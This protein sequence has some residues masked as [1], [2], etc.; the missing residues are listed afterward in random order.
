MRALKAVVISLGVLCLGA[1][2][3]LVYLVTAK[4]GARVEKATVISAPATPAPL[5]GDLD[6]G[7][8]RGSRIVSLQGAGDTL[9]IHLRLPD[10]AERV[11]VVD[12]RAGAVIGRI[13]PGEQ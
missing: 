11:I 5:W 12:P 3:V 13:S 1:F 9:A 2:G 10:G 8:P 4:T 6:L 7:M